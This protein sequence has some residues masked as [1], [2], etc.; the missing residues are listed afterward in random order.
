MEIKKNSLLS[1]FT[2]TMFCKNIYYAYNFIFKTKKENIKSE[3]KINIVFLVERTNIW[4]SVASIYNA[5]EKNPMV[6][7]FLLALPPCRNM[8][9]DL[10]DNS[11]YEHCLKINPN[12]VK[13]YD[14]NSK[15]YFDIKKLDPD[16]IFINVPYYW[17]YPEE[18]RI[19]NLVRIAKLCYVPY[20][21]NM[22]QS[23]ILDIS[24]HRD[25]LMYISYFFAE[26]RV[27]YDYAKK[28]LR[29]SQLISGKRLYDIGFPRF[30]LYNESEFDSK[31]KN[32]TLMWLPR[33][34]TGT[35]VEEGGNEPSSFFMMKDSIADYAQKT[36]DKVII[37]PHPLAFDNYIKRGLMTEEEVE[38]YKN[39]ILYNPNTELDES[40]SYMEGLRSADVLI[41]DF[42]SLVAEFFIT[43]KPII[44]FGNGDNFPSYHIEMYNSFYHA[45]TW[46]ETEKLINNLKRGIDLKKEQRQIAIKHFMNGKPKNVGEHI[47][48]ILVE[49]YY[50]RR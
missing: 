25:L 8:E 14:N 41:S 46:E 44:Y 43:G 35:E 5:A 34:T 32:I 3:K 6:N 24:V 28:R 18:Y 23:R 20:G 15:E 40:S 13:V 48:N 12:A 4:S 38:E 45:S 11:V 26:S 49:D 1:R 21:Y 17:E 31:K 47:V 42:S 39:K 7:V 50:K 2:N 36:G 16:Y 33:W 30:D 37:R 27:T 22:L 10:D 9:L 29:L 19:K